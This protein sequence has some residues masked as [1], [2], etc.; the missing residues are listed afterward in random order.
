MV[1]VLFHSPH[2]GAF[3]LS[4]AVLCT[5]G[6]WKY[7]ALP[8]S[9]GRFTR[10]IRV[11]GYSRTLKKLFRFRLQGFHL[12]GRRFPA[13]SAIKTICNFFVHQVHYQRLTTPRITRTICITTDGLSNSAVWAYSLSL[14]ATDEILF[15]FFS[16]R[17]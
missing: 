2:R 8:V 10:A 12:L 1:S 4:L 16:S 17:Y 13:T 3:H 7:L 15:S 6:L 9:S 14:A 11:S 5:I